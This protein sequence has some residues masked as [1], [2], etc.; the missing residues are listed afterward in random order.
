MLCSV[1]AVVQ[2]KLQKRATLASMTGGF[3]VA[4]V[5]SSIVAFGDSSLCSDIFRRHNSGEEHFL[6]W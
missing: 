4:D 5:Y 3:E 6:H 1:L 2:V